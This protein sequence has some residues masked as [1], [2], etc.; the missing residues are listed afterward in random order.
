M[1]P[2][3]PDELFSVE[4]SLYPHPEEDEATR[5][6]RC[7]GEQATANCKIAGFEPSAAFLAEGERIIRGEITVEESI[8]RIVEKWKAVGVAQQAAAQKQRDDQKNI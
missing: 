3:D 2:N 7:A 1:S 5:R 8:A 4:N 6:R